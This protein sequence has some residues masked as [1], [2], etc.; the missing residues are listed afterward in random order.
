MWIGVQGKARNVEKAEHTRSY[1][2]I[3]SRSATPPWTL[4][5]N[6]EVRF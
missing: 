1:V 3:L 4:R 2:S 5:R 6:F